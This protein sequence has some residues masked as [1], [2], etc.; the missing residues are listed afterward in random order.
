MQQSFSGN[1]EYPRKIQ[2]NSKKSFAAN[3]T[4]PNTSNPERRFV[5]LV[6]RRREARRR[7]SP[8]I[9]YYEVGSDLT[10]GKDW[11]DV[12]DQMQHELVRE[13]GYSDGS[14]IIATCNHNFIQVKKVYTLRS[15]CQPG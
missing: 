4:T 10:C 14:T 5:N 1:L 6:M 13:F 11:M 7:F 12:T 3:I 15:L 8:G 2:G 9:Q